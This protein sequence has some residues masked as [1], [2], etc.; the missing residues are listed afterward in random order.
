MIKIKIGMEIKKSYWV[1]R[2][3]LGKKR[4]V[5]I[6]KTYAKNVDSEK[7]NGGE[8]AFNLLEMQRV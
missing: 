2:N 6:Y 7:P 8:P 5:F 3:L 1:K 4:W